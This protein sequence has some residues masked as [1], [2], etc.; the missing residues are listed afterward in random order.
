MLGVTQVIIN[1]G[2]RRRFDRQL[3]QQSVGQSL[4][5]LEFRFFSFP[6]S[7]IKVLVYEQLHNLI[8]SIKQLCE[9]G[10]LMCRGL[11]LHIFQCLLTLTL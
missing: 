5:L 10:I 2:A 9:D 1:F 11:N 4:H 7:F 8:Y 6:I 3:L